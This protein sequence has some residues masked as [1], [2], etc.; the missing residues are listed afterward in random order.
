MA[1]PRIAPLAVVILSIIL[2]IAGGAQTGPTQP[3]LR[4]P[5]NSP[6]PSSTYNFQGAVLMLNIVPDPKG[7]LD[8]QALV[9]LV[10]KQTSAVMWQ[11]THDRGQAVFY[12]LSVGTYDVE[13]STVGYVPAQS[14]VQV[15]RGLTTYHVDVAIKRDATSADPELSK[16]ADLS[17]HVRKQLDRAVR[18]LKSSDYRHASKELRA[19]YQAAPTSADVSF[20]LGYVAMQQGDL[21]NAKTH[22]VRAADLDPHNARVLTSLG[23]IYLKQS[24][25][26]KA[27]QTLV[28]ATE[29]DNKSWLSH[30]LLA[31]SYLRT[32]NFSK[33]RDEAALAINTGQKGADN[34][35]IILGEALANLG[36][37]VGALRAFHKFLQTSPGSPLASQVQAL[38][39]QVETQQYQARQNIGILAELP[40]DSD[41]LIASAQASIQK[42]QPAGIDETKPPLVAGVSCPQEQLIASTGERVKQF[43]DEISQFA[44]I[45]QIL[46]EQLD[47]MG[48]PVSK[49]KRDFNY[50]ATISENQ[51]GRL[52]VEEDRLQ[53]SD[54]GE[55]PEQIAT[56][57]LPTLALIFHP[58]MRDN[59]DLAC[60]GLGQWNGQ[61][62]WLVRFQQR[63]DRPRS[64]KAYVIGANLYPLAL[65]GRAWI[66]A[67]TY[68]I[69]R[70]ETELVKP[71]PEIKLLAD[72]EIVEY[73]PVR[74]ARKNT[75]LWL[76]KTAELYF[77]LQRRRYYRRHSFDHFMLFAVDSNDKALSPP[78]A[79]DEQ[80]SCSGPPCKTN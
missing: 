45:E 31:E 51:N 64:I 32:N 70:I 30:H 6:N 52:T 12:D 71:M 22:L 56:R 62:T 8:R 54:M 37:P 15:L 36:E 76:P 73:G 11:T 17:P 46:H 21:Q 80:T 23:Q 58:A 41:S 68:Q 34:S 1:D 35:Q 63:K 20:L 16:T 65:K 72:H 27:K 26:E 19:A 79:K 14:E 61:A 66:S 9:K 7:I 53:R 2:S 25:Y 43:M 3:T 10:N 48:N 55:F 42:W 4:N 60:E 67:E 33:A 44:A 13:V 47:A 49:E 39:T 5:F 40:S 50:I 74:F 18:D 59:F 29:A 57:G 28:A 38:V 69:A 75:T 24:D 78:S 77:D